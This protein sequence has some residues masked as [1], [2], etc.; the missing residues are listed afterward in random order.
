MADLVLLNP[1]TVADRATLKD[2]SQLSAGIERV[3]VNGRSVWQQG[4]T[5]AAHPGK[6]LK[7]ASSAKPFTCARASH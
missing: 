5:T 3:W 2:P 7:R 1:D 6:L 4:K